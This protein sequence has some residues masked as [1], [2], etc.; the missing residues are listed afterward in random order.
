MSGITHEAFRLPRRQELL[1]EL[2]KYRE[3]EEDDLFDIQRNQEDP[4]RRECFTKTRHDD[5]CLLI[6]LNSKSSSRYYPRDRH[7]A[8][9][10][11]E[12]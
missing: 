1:N 11:F 8:F 12:E 3:D 5:D 6:D 7:R 4:Y 10:R 9:E 2:P